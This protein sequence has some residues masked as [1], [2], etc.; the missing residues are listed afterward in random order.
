MT[1]RDRAESL[2]QDALMQGFTRKQSV[3]IAMY[4]VD[5]IIN[6]GN[7]DRIEENYWYDVMDYLESIQLSK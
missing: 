6:Y 4:G 3:E 7:V 2:I 1:E 5:K